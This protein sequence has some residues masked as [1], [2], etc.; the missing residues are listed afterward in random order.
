MN[1][2]SINYKINSIERLDAIIKKSEKF[3]YNNK[4]IPNEILFRSSESC[5]FFLIPKKELIIL[6]NH[7]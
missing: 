7:I 6:Y 5:S 2:T 3:K 1:L 4:H